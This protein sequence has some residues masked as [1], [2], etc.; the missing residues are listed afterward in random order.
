MK[1]RSFIFQSLA[2]LGQLGIASSVLAKSRHVKSKQD[3]E[4]SITIAAAG[5]TVLGFNLQDDF[6]LLL[7][8]GCTKE[9]LFDRYFHGVRDVLETADISIVNLECPFTERGEKL[10][11]NFNFR[12]RPEMVEMLKRASIKAVTC[13]NNHAMDYGVDGMTDTRQTLDDAGIGHFGT[14][15]NLSEARAPLIMEKNGLKVGFL[16]Y[17]F[18]NAEDMIE[19]A[20]I[21]ALDDKPGVSGCYTDLEKI[22]AMVSEDVAAL[23][24]NV[25]AV[26]PFFHW[27][28]EG[29]Y[30]VRDY[31][32]EI[33]HLCIN[34]GARAV[35]GAH[36]HRVHGVEVYKGAPIFYSLGNFVY[37]GVKNPPDNLTMI[38]QLR[39][40]HKRVKA[41]IIPVQFTNWP[42]VPFQPVILEGDQRQQA[43]ARVTDLSSVFRHTLPMLRPR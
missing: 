6:D 16:G 11:K 19:P 37:G 18:Q 36:P 15:N 27:G 1:R 29:K 42:D 43:I 32:I 31:Q 20:E 33:A 26:I 9:E 25:D 39:I 40:D 12:A 14:G 28:K 21:Y 30:V 23:A 41:S 5:D 7:A 4:P 35:L 34:Q 10:A 17:Y 2:T 13:A 3:N 8:Q 22:K 24:S 38:A